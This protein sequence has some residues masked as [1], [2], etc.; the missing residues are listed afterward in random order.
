MFEIVLYVA[1]GLIAATILGTIAMIL[2]EQDQ[3]T[4]AV[5]ADLTFYPMIGFYVVWCMLNDSQINYEVALL[6][7]LV[8]GVLPTMSL[9]RIISK[10]RR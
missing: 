3:F 7:G 1:L 10:G 8:G 2:K 6:A 4:R 5:V 9:A